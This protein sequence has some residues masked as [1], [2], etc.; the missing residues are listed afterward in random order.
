MEVEYFNKDQFKLLRQWK[1][2]KCEKSNPEHKIVYDKLCKAYSSLEHWGTEVQ[3]RLFPSG[4][5]PLIRKRPTNQ[6]NI[7]EEYLW[8]RIYPDRDIPIDWLTYQFTINAQGNSD[9]TDGFYV[10]IYIAEKKVQNM[11]S[12]LKLK[13]FSIQ[14]IKDY[15]K[16]KREKYKISAYKSVEDGLAMTFEELV[17][18]SIKEIN[19][20]S[21]TYD[22][23][24]K[25]LENKYPFLKSNS[26]Q[27]GII[28]S[29]E[30]DDRIESP[31]NHLKPWSQSQMKP[32]NRIYYGPPGTGKTFKLDEDIKNYQDREKKRYSFVTFHQSYGYEDFIE[33]LRPIL[34]V[35]DSMHKDATGDIRY[36][37]SDGAFKKLCEDARKDP[38]NRY[39]MIID[40]INRGNISKIFGE[41]ITLIETDKRNKLKVTLPYSKQEFTVPDNVDLIGT[42]NTADRTLALLDIA[43]RR[44]F[45]FIKFLPKPE[46][47]GVIKTFYK[48]GEINI[49]LHK[50]LETINKRIETLYDVDHTIGHAYF[51]KIKDMDP[52]NQF[53]EL[54]RIFKNNIIPLLED[55]FFEDPRKM[56]LVLGDNQKL[57][58]LQFIHINDA[59]QRIQRLFGGDNDLSQDAIRSTYSI[60]DD[61]FDNPEAFVG[62]YSEQK[63]D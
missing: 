27:S 9:I 51:I 46:E 16:E 42:M 41:L 44:R 50:L 29:K 38:F 7:F 4:K 33:G 61:A 52:K 62:I 53:E 47:L 19:G 26:N 49:S 1:K 55:Y 59:D 56:R 18:W 32:F 3:T 5:K 15:I 6:G 58:E 8:L 20:F 40:E 13:E 36:E 54:I 22:E 30:E 17:D 39:A 57:K 21:P 35:S 63:N 24:V 34:N 23:L 45:D 25:E 14:E 12:E 11:I 48:D 60:N 31:E 10:E 37:I 28:S 43:L 2:K